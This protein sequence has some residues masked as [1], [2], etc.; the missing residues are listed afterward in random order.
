M[1][2]LRDVKVA[3]GLQL[4][5]KDSRL[6]VGRNTKKQYREHG[7][8]CGHG[9]RGVRELGEL[10]LPHLILKARRIKMRR[11]KTQECLLPSETQENIKHMD[12]DSA[13]IKTN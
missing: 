7:V 9:S 6:W 5:W 1:S 11:E 8:Q 4:P 13:V 3:M 10:E 2:V 12:G